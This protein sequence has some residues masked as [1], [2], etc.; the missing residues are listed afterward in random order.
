[1]TEQFTWSRDELRELIKNYLTKNLKI[2][3]T[4]GDWGN[5]DCRKITVSLDD[6]E[7]CCDYFDVFERQERSYY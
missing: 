4:N 6:E 1:M 2:S 7:L 3:V 5:E